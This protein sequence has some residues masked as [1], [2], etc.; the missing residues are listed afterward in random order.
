MTSAHT[1]KGKTMRDITLMPNDYIVT[2]VKTDT[3][4]EYFSNDDAVYVVEERVV[5]LVRCGK[6]DK[7]KKN[8]FCLEYMRYEKDDNGFCSHG[9]ESNND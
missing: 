1:E 4:C 2:H 6:C 8:G 7:R 3:I 9:R 5:P